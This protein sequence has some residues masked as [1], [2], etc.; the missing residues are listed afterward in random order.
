MRK[1]RTQTTEINVGAF[2]EAQKQYLGGGGEELLKYVNNKNIKLDDSFPS[3]SR[4]VGDTP[5]FS[6][7]LFSCSRLLNSADP[8]I[9]EPG[10]G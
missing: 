9:S 10:T 1:W 6:P 7:L 5:Q 3:G 4:M 8:T 2:R